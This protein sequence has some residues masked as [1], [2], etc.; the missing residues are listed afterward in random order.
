[1]HHL[2]GLQSGFDH[3][4]ALNALGVLHL[5]HIVTEVLAS[6]GHQTLLILQK[7]TKDK[8]EIYK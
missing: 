5:E 2:L 8:G 4:P 1:M 3:Q 6:H 7:Q